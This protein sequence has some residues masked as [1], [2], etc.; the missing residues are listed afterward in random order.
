MCLGREEL[1]RRRV[2]QQ[3][4]R[5]HEVATAMQALWRGHSTRRF[6]R[7]TRRNASRMKILKH[8]SASLIQR[9]WRGVL[10]RRTFAV[11]AARVRSMRVRQDQGVR[12]LQRVVRGRAARRRV[13]RMRR[14]HVEEAAILSTAALRLQTKYRS[15]L[16][17][18]IRRRL[19]LDKEV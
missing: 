5:L 11:Y 2:W 13:A 1:A 17:K 8:E 9:V 18:R 3:E 7:E 10:G 4:H 19:A 14:R 12:E 6:V 16:A 15:H